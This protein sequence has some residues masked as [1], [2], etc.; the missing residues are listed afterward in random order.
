MPLMTP[1]AEAYQATAA[2]KTP[3]MAPAITMSVLESKCRT[4]L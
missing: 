4:S 2:V 3:A 1:A